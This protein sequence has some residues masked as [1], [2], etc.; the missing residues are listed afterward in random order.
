MAINWQVWR[1]PME[2]NTPPTIDSVTPFEGGIVTRHDDS[3][4][5]LR[6]TFYVLVNK[7]GAGAGTYV[8]TW[9]VQNPNKTA[10]QNRQAFNVNE[11]VPSGHTEMLLLTPGT[12]VGHANYRSVSIGA[13]AP[14]A[15]T[16][17]QILAGLRSGDN[18][19]STAIDNEF[20]AEITRAVFVSEVSGSIFQAEFA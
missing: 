2:I 9:Q 18:F 13:V 6:Y 4:D 8:E 14:D 10:L 20:A 11:A 17:A 7:A 15:V 12:A 3:S 5:K 19:P 1:Q 16:D